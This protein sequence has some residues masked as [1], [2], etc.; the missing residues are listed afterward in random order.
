M[1]SIAPPWWRPTRWVLFCALALLSFSALA[2]REETTFHV[3]INV[4]SSDFYVLPINPQFLEREQVMSYNVVTERLSP[5]RE[6]FD[7]RNVLGGINARLGFEPVLFN[8]VDLI[9]LIVTFNG[10][11]LDLVDTLVVSEADAKVGK[12]VALE[13][14]ALAPVDGYRPGQYF[15]SVQIVFDALQP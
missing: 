8:G 14:A 12:R 13:I 7:V 5:L 11:R 4:P 15:G 2:V 3:S 9:S 6:L 1:S 10:Q